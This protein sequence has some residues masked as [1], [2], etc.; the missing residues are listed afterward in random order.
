MYDWNTLISTWTHIVEVLEWLWRGFITDP[1]KVTDY[2]ITSTPSSGL[3]F[4]LS[5]GDVDK[6][7][8]EMWYSQPI[9][10]GLYFGGSRTLHTL[11]SPS[12]M[13]FRL[14]FTCDFSFSSW[15]SQIERALSGYSCEEKHLLLVSSGDWTLAVG[16]WPG[17]K[18]R[19]RDK[20]GSIY[21]Y[22]F[23]RGRGTNLIFITHPGFLR[24]LPHFCSWDLTKQWTNIV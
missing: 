21:L 4:K 5:D 6:S 11:F 7:L 24:W 23:K 18:D 3:V 10:S 19:G 2:Y 12:L 1:D 9:D 17:M 14:K 16:W 15:C 22:F 8:P 13:L 20:S